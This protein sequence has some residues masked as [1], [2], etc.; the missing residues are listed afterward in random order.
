MGLATLQQRVGPGSAKGIATRNKRTL[1]R[2]SNDKA[3]EG[4]L[5]L[6]LGARMLLRVSIGPLYDSTWE[7]AGGTIWLV[8]EALNLNIFIT[9]T[10]NQAKRSNTIV[11]LLGSCHLN[12]KS[13]LLGKQV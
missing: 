9:Q 13:A 4:L 5:A 12:G 3:T 1:L 10:A 2:A 8:M 6:L 11:F 7:F